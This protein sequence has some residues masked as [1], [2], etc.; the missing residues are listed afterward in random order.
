MQKLVT[1]ILAAVALSASVSAMAQI[2][3]SG[4]VTLASDYRF[5]GISQLEGEF[6]PA[7]QGG[8][9]I[10]GGP[11]LYAGVWASNVNFTGGAIETDLYA[12][13][14]FDI[15]EG[16]TGDV[17]FMYYGYPEE[18]DQDLDYWEVYGSV[19][20]WKAKI[21][22]NYSDDYFAETGKFFYVYGDLSFPFAE[23]YSVDAHLGYSAFDDDQLQDNINLPF[24]GEC[25]LS[26]FMC[27]EDKYLD[28]SL[29][30]TASDVAGVDIS[31]TYIGIDADEE[32][33]GLSGSEAADLVDDTV[34]LAISK[35][36]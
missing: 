33:F 34:V 36:L 9:D 30:V 35:S 22:L 17:G 3:V 16:I 31:L 2:E 13:W 12:G 7:I 11:G 29:G 4:N 28:W 20:F 6:S 10:A 1:T 24:F 5:R 23:R 19:S 14:G 21:G 27:N 25:V 32:D 26:G 15:T 18:D 8:F